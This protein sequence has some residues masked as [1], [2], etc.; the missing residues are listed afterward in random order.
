MF[1]YQVVSCSNCG[2]GNM[3]ALRIK[4]F[5]KPMVLEDVPRPS[6]GYGQVLVRLSVT[7]VC[8]TDLHQ[9]KGADWPALT[10]IMRQTGTTVVGHEGVGVVEEVG[11][12]VTRLRRGDRVGIPWMNY[13]CG[14]CEACLSGYPYWC[15]NVKYTSAHV[16][17]TYAEYALIHEVAAPII[18]RELPDEQ[19]A[20]MLC[21]GITA[22]GAVRKL[23]TVLR[24]PPGKPVAIIGAAGGLGHYAVQIAKAFGYKVIGIDVGAERVKFVE[25]L[26]ADYAVD[27]TEAERFVKE[28]F[29]GVYASLVFAPKIKGYEL[30]LKILK[31]P[32]GSLVAVGLPAQAEGVIPITPLQSI[33]YNVSII[34]SL[35]GVTHEFEELFK[36]AVEGKVKSHI[37]R[38]ISCNPEEVMKLFEDLEKAKYL[39]RAVIRIGG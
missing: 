36:L 31:S 37:S 6:P 22:Y 11:P 30:G 3:K 8:H 38:V 15:K 13:W 9:W 27:A 7:G 39:G 4:E 20:P 24:I 29:D 1:I 17:G 23:V 19:V 14:G 21:G 34:P 35:V 28:K 5:G 2:K 16:D 12:G 25:S 18:P 10:D 26:G 33:F 32:F